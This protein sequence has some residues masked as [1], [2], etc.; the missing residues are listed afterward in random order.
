MNR[1][2]IA[3]SP[4]SYSQACDTSRPRSRQ[5]T[6][7]R[8]GLGDQMLGNLKTHA[9]AA[10][11]RFPRQHGPEIRQPASRVGTATPR[12]RR[13]ASSKR[14]AGQGGVEGDAAIGMSAQ[15]NECSSRPN[16]STRGSPLLA[17]ERGD[18]RGLVRRWRD[19]GRTPEG[20]AARVVRGDPPGPQIEIIDAGPVCAFDALSMMTTGLFR[21]S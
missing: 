12:H 17:L 10:Y 21:G 11:P 5:T 13:T 8:A 7:L 18:E 15:S 2:A 9:A 6:A 20:P 4:I 1:T 3:A 14:A 19:A 16:A